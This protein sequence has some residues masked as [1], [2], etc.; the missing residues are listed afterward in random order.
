MRPSILGADGNILCQVNPIREGFAALGHN[1][2]ADMRHPDTDFV[3]VG[4]PPFD[5][6]LDLAKSREKKVIFN[7]LDIP[8]HVVE[9]NDVI[10]KLS[11]QLPLANRV[12]AISKAVQ[13]DLKNACGIDSEVIYYPMKPVKFTG[14]KKY[15]QFKVAMVGRLLDPNKYAS[16]AISALIRCGFDEKDVAIIGPEYVG[17]GT[18]MGLIND[19]VLNDIYNSVDY[20]IMLDKNAGIGLPAIEAACCGA[21][22]IV[23]AHLATFD[24]FWVQSPLGLHYQKIRNASELTKLIQSIESDKKWKQEIKT[25]L[26]GYSELYFRPKFDKVNVAKRIIEVYQSI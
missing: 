3:F 23:A 13:A 2:I 1:H 22:P 11:E 14:E 20:V 6:Y 17:W 18:R 19:E 25:D 4:N 12:T 24:E 21:I 15:P 9:I 7:V 26:L 5:D 16:V 8:W 10:K